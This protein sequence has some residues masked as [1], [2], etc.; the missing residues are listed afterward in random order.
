MNFGLAVAMASA[1]TCRAPLSRWSGLPDDK[2]LEKNDVLDFMEITKGVALR[3]RTELLKW[4]SRAAYFKAQLPRGASGADVG[5][6]KFRFRFQKKAL[7]AFLESS[8]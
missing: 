1:S 3:T 7:G 2:Y 4:A 8:V 5:G 6:F